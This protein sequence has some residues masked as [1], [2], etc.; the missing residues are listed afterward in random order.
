MHSPV[1]RSMPAVHTMGFP[2]PNRVRSVMMI[3]RFMWGL[4]DSKFLKERFVAAFGVNDD[5]V[6]M[7]DL[8][9]SVQR[10]VI[11]VV[12]KLAFQPRVVAVVLGVF[13]DGTGDVANRVAV[14]A[15]SLPDIQIASVREPDLLVL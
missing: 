8:G 14:I 6:K 9:V 11:H 13:V 3:E 10:P 4:S 12:A 15:G 5:L 2:S 1:C 7:E